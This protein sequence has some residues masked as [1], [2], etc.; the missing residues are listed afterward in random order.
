[1]EPRPERANNHRSEREADVQQ[2]VLAALTTVAVTA[3]L[4]VA[5]TTAAYAIN[6]VPCDG[7]FDR[8]A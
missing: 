8:A 1:M 4:T 5:S 3:S 6:E 2:T 7:R